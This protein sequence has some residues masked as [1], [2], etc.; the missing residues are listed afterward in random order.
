LWRG[1]R[2]V[3]LNPVRAGLVQDPGAYAWSSAAGHLSGPRSYA[4]PAL[5][6]SVW[7]DAGRQAGWKKLLAQAATLD[8]VV[9]LRRCTY[10]GKPF[11]SPDFLAEMEARFGRKWL[12]PGRPRKSV[13]PEKG[14]GRSASVSAS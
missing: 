5:D 7:Q 6:W 4:G 9:E 11:G 14:T 8:E 3:E 13:E 1:L 2:Y 12:P 10:A